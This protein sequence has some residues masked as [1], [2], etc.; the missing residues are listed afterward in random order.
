MMQHLL[1]HTIYNNDYELQ[2]FRFIF[3]SP[4]Y[5]KGYSEQ[6]GIC[7]KMNTILMYHRTCTYNL[8]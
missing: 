1:V 8:Q 7:D 5:T 2:S 4:S 3:D 6:V